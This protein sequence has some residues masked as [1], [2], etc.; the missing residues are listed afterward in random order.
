MATGADAALPLPDLAR[1]P[2]SAGFVGREAEL[3]AFAEQL[4]TAHLV[5]I[6]GRYTA[7]SISGATQATAGSK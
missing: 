2:E 4:E 6:A 1:P 7:T 5:V 3:A